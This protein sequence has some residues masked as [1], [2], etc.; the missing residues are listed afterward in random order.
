M[1]TKM[2]GKSFDI[3][4]MWDMKPAEFIALHVP[5]PEHTE[6]YDYLGAVFFGDFKLEFIQNADGG[7]RNLFRYGEDESNG[8]H[9]YDYLEDGTPYG[10]YC[11]EADEIIL[12][13]SETFDRFAADVEA[14]VIDLLR[15]HIW[16]LPLAAHDTDPNKWYPG[17]RMDYARDITRES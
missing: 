6:T 7:Y 9:M 13:L 17:D 16:M 12:P 1:E 11:D 15:R 10:E 3:H 8:S 14:Q 2:L 5:H 4:F